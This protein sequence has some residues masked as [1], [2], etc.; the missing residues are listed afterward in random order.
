MDF[1]RTS[2]RLQAL[3]K[4]ILRAFHFDFESHRSEPKILRLVI[5]HET[6]DF[7]ILPHFILFIQKGAKSS[8]GTEVVK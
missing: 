7:P 5:Q 2:I 8:E 6:A 4:S 3:S 1:K